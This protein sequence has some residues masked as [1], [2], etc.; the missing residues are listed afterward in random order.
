MTNADPRLTKICTA[1]PII[2]VLVVHDV[3]HAVPLAQALV[4]GGLTSLEVTLRTDAALD[5]IAEMAQVPGCTPGAGTVLTAADVDAVVKAGGQ[6]AVSPGSSPAIIDACAAN[7]LPLLP[8]AATS[9]EAMALLD[10]GFTYQKFFPAEAIGGAKA[11]G[12][13]AGPL[14]QIKFC[15]TGGV[16]P[17]NAQSYLALPN[18]ICAGGSW[19]A[20]SNLVTAGDW[21]AI[22]K[23]A[24]QAAQLGA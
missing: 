24:S 10:R 5:V 16:T 18:V 12:A 13:M 22:T 1:A 4:A 9:T 15:P 20:P 23:I 6:F 2:P 21:D 17:Q 19:V 8:G 3:A 11:L 7:D 14:P